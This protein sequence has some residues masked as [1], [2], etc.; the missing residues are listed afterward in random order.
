[1]K[2]LI[3]FT[4]WDGQELV[5]VMFLTNEEN[6]ED[7]VSVKQW[8]RGWNKEPVDI[9]RVLIDGC[10]SLYFEAPEGLTLDHVRGAA[11]DL[12][13]IETPSVDYRDGSVIF[14]VE[15]K[16]EGGSNE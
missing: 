2:Q 10:S 15:E 3:A 8:A 6:E 11:L 9:A 13:L 1:M 4:S 14:F 5:S 7:L 16:K 12:H